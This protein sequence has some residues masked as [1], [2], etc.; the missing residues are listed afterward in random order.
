MELAGLIIAVVGLAV[1]IYFGVQAI[2]KRQSQ[3]QTV[4]SRSAA[5]Q[6]GRDTRIGK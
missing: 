3:K 6:S 1:A 4:K 5:I 2:R